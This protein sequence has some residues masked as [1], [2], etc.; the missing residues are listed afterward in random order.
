MLF[1][2]VTQ[3]ILVLVYR[4]LGQ[5]TSGTAVHGLLTLEH[6]TDRLSQNAS[7]ST[8][9]SFVTSQKSK[10]LVLLSSWKKIAVLR[11]KLILMCMT[12]FLKTMSTAVNPHIVLCLV[13][14]STDIVAGQYVTEL[15][16]SHG[17][18]L[19]QTASAYIEDVNVTTV[20]CRPLYVLLSC[21]H[22]GL[23]ES[24]K[25]V[26]IGLKPTTSELFVCTEFCDLSSGLQLR[27][28]TI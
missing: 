22:D 17:G 2:D 3:L 26:C 10:H 23:Q 16:K 24:L 4:L 28:C 20:R 21:C 1:W 19:I 5:P 9:I 7:T 18:E 6:G 14:C 15:Y 8:N 12:V 27:I 13:C 25:K 11:L